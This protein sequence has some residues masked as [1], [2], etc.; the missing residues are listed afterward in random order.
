MLSLT[1]PLDVPHV[2][3]CRVTLEVSSVPCLMN[4]LRQVSPL[5]QSLVLPTG[6][7]LLADGNDHSLVG[8]VSYGPSGC[9]GANFGVYAQVPGN[10]EGFGFIQSSVCGDLGF[11]DAEF[12][13][14]AAMMIVTKT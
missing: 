5:T 2:L 13:T 12:C 6:P 3:N 14:V 9:E 11:L 7:I 1:S 8:I 10:D 4:K